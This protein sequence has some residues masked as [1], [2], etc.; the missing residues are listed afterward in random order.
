MDDRRTFLIEIYKQMFGD[1]NRHLTVIWQSVS[2]VVGAFALL[3][4]SEKGVVP[5]DVA[6][7]LIVLLCGWLYAHMLDAG[8]WYNR[9]LVIIANIERQFLKNSDLKEI[10]FYWGDHRSVKNKMITHIRIQAALG[11]SLAILVLAFHFSTRVWQGFCAQDS[12]FDPVRTLPYISAFAVF[13]FCTR[14]SKNRDNAY[15]S[16]R[17][18]SPGIDVDTTGINFG[19][20]HSVDSVN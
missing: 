11:V 18:N 1:I 4:L 8:Y 2:V 20:G 6:I 16:F 5:A 15:A 14:L 19:V 12:T 10:H 9:N 3:A 13:I 17:N 7:A